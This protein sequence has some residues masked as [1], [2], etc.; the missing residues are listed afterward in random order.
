MYHTIENEDIRVTVSDLGATLVQ[1]IEKKSGQDIVLG[2]DQEEDY[3][4]HKGPHLGATVGRN[5][6]R[7]GNARFELNGKTYQ[8]DVN[9]NGNQLHGGS[10]NF[11]FRRWD[12]EEKKEDSITFT[13]FSEDGDQGFPGNLRVRVTY[14]L[15]GNRLHMDYEGV[16]DQDTLF[17]MTNHAYFNLGDEDILKEELKIFTDTYSPTDEHSLTLETSLPAAGTPYD[18]CD[19]RVIGEVISTLPCGIDN[20]YVFE[21]TAYKHMASLRNE[22]FQLD[23]YSDLPDMHFYTA[24]YLDGFKGKDGVIYG[25]YKGA[26]LECQYYP[27]GINYEGYLKPVLK[28]GEKAKHRITYQITQR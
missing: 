23:V 20:N 13:L 18:F 1:F 2:F 6:N 19:Y 9:D 17:N 15:E 10:D 5:A 4:A 26:T 12:V 22:R 16:A 27:N 11:S 8:L 21:D 25:P 14:S 28:K 7:I 3:L 24:Y